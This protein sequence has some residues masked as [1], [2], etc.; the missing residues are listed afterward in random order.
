MGLFNSKITA[1]KIII[2]KSN[3]KK[4]SMSTNI[5]K[6]RFILALSIISLFVSIFAYIYKIFVKP[7]QKY[8]LVFDLDCTLIYIAQLNTYSE[9]NIRSFRTPDGIIVLKKNGKGIDDCKYEKYAVFKRPFSHI[10]L[11]IISRWNNLCIFTAS[12]KSYADKIIDTYYPDIH[13]SQ[14]NYRDKCENGKDLNLIN[15]TDSSIKIL[16]DDK[17]YNNKKNQKFYHISPYTMYTNYDYQMIKLC[18]DILWLN[19]C[20]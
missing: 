4:I 15:G 14:R 16:I 1:D 2:K 17:K 6:K 5:G 3:R 20:G 9:N 8:T 10:V 7:V 12:T 18:I 19:F 11:K 13:F